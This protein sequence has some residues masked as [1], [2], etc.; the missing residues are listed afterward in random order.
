[1]RVFP[2]LLRAGH[3]PSLSRSSPAQSPCPPSR[4]FGKPVRVFHKDRK[5]NYVPITAQHASASTAPGGIFSN[6][7]TGG[8]QI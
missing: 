6:T 8:V 7:N 1:M 2:L 4:T 5:I 3:L